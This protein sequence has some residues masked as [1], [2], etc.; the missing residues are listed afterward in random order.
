MSDLEWKEH[1][2]PHIYITI[3]MCLF[4]HIFMYI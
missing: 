2:Q 4:M 1:V 3:N